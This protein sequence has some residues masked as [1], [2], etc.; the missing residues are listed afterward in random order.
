MPA[1]TDQLHHRNSQGREGYAPSRMPWTRALVVAAA[2]IVVS[3]QLL[4][5]PI[6]GLADNGDFPKLIG[7]YGLSSP[8]YW[9]YIAVRYPFQAN[10]HYDPGFSS[11]EQIFIR[12][13]IGISRLLGGDGS[14]DIRL[15]GAVHSAVFLLALGLF[16]PLLA[17]ASRGQRLA[18]CT[19]VLFV[20]TDVMYISFFNSLYMDVSAFLMLMLAAVFYL[21]AIAWKHRADAVLFVAGSV[22]LISSKPQHAALALWIAA[23]AWV[24]RGALWGGRKPAAAAAAGVVLLTGWA[25]SRFAA[26]PGYSAN[27]CFNAVFLQIL[28]AAHD[29]N[30]TMADLGLDSTDRI[31][32]GKTAYSPG[33][34]MG[35]PA[36]SQAFA[37]K[38]SY[39]KLARFYLTHPRD[40]WRAL[41]SGLAQAGRERERIGNFPAS[42]RRPPTAEATSF[43]LWSDLKRALFY[44]HAWRLLLSFLGAAGLVIFLLSRHG[45]PH[46]GAMAGAL[47]LIGTALTEMLIASLADALD[48][49]RHHL[50]F[51]AEFDMLILAA[52]WLGIESAWKS[53]SR[54]R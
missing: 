39:P 38:V 10:F 30:R 11:S 41:R 50:L 16:V 8:A 27:N 17:P 5:P 34:R 22:L 26:P 47:V 45:P 54:V 35:E 31:W 37:K 51:H 40:A 42:A 25:T 13:A 14:L 3:G 52:L 44:A 7:K 15:V 1:A 43:A 29:V 19:A 28:P 12:I 49:V 6:V 48:V 24:A 20:F 4:A 36:F 23:L 32:I 33:S 46:A 18:Y 2:A 53:G 9:E 21:R